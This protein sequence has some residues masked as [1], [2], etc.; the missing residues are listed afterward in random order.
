LDNSVQEG[1]E[2]IRLAKTVLERELEREDIL[3][4]ESTVG[5][6]EGC[7]RGNKS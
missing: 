6:E 4:Q 2:V 3:M 7:A 1:Y 5:K